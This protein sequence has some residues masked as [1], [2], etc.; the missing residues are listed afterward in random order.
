MS[1]RRS[2]FQIAVDVLSVMNE[3]EN[4]STGIMYAANLSW[5]TLKNGLRLLVSKG[6]AEM[7]ST[8]KKRQKRYTITS[9]GV[10]TLRYYE[11]LGELVKIEKTV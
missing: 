9:E 7:V 6:Y 8:E 10:N 11:R 4:R 5:N 1:P 3:G 2:S